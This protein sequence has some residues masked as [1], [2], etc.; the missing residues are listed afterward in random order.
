MA[1]TTYFDW[2]VNVYLLLHNVPRAAQHSLNTDVSSSRKQPHWNQRCHCRKGRDTSGGV[3]LGAT[4]GVLCMWSLVHNSC[5]CMYLS[6]LGRS[7]QFVLNSQCHWE[8]AAATARA[9]FLSSSTSMSVPADITTL[10]SMNMPMETEMRQSSLFK[11]LMQDLQNLCSGDHWWRKF[12][13]NG[14]SKP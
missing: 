1:I 11:V 8:C 14:K 3:S 7:V 2:L 6:S 9:G 10:V 13:A 4:R 12:S 5:L